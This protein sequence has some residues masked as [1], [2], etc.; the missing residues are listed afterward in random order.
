MAKPTPIPDTFLH[1]SLWFGGTGF[2][3]ITGMGFVARAGDSP[4]WPWW[5]A[6]PPCLIPLLCLLR[7]EH[8]GTIKIVDMGKIESRVWKRLPPLP[9]RVSIALAVFLYAV[10]GV[11]FVLEQMSAWLPDKFE[12]I[13]ELIG[14]L[15]GART[16]A[17]AAG[18]AILG[19]LLWIPA[20]WKEFR[21]AE[22][23]KQL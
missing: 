21:R 23:E 13:A 19:L 8:T 4:G 2:I 17:A 15:V 5:V 6:G 9:A 14:S 22:A 12:K 11:S 16:A 18:L 3:V 20:V 10:Q 1:L 7:L